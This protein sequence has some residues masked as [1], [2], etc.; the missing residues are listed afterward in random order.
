MGVSAIN[1]KARKLDKRLRKYGLARRQFYAI[2]E[3]QHF[4]C[5]ICTLR[6]DT[7]SCQIDHNHRTGL[8][9]GLLCG[10]CNQGLGN[11]RDNP[12]IV[13]YAEQYLRKW[14]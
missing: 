7:E 13:R 1:H 10:R 6:I 14:E 5:D 11:F 3:D 2:L 8:V 12:E 4:Q 9:R